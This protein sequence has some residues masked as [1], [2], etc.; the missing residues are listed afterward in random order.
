MVLKKLKKLMI[1]YAM[2]ADCIILRALW[3]C[4]QLTSPQTEGAI[5]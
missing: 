1:V 2:I 5:K 4:V 3:L